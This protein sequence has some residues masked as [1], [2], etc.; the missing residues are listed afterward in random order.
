MAV[1]TG[2]ARTGPMLLAKERTSS[3]AISS[4]PSRSNHERSYSETASSSVSAVPA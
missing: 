3:S 4:V 1:V 2:T